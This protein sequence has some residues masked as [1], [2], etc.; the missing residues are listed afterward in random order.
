M[1]THSAHRSRPASG[2]RAS[3][4]RRFA[5]VASTVGASA[6]ALFPVDGV[7]AIQGGASATDM[8]PSVVRLTYKGAEL[9][10]GT[11]VGD[12]WVLSAYHCLT[13][14]NNDWGNIGVE[15]WRSGTVGPGDVY[16]SKVASAPK[17]PTGATAPTRNKTVGNYDLMLLPTASPMAPWVKTVPMAVGWPALGTTLTEYGYG[18]TSKSGAPSSS[19]QKT[20]DGDLK[21][22]SCDS[23]G[24]ADWKVGHICAQGSRSTAWEGDSGG[25]L[26]WWN[27]GYWQQVG[28]FSMYPG[29]STGVHWQAYWSE[30]DTA[31]R[32]WIAGI[33]RPSINAGTILR[34]PD[35][36]TSWLYGSDGY[37]HWIP[38]GTTYNCLVSQGSTSLNWNIRTI[39]SIPDMVGSG[40]WAHCTSPVTNPPP[41][42]T[43]AE[44]E[45]SH[46]VNTFTNYHNASGMGPRIDPYA[47]VQVSC[48]VYDPYIVSASP[49]GYWYRIAS[50][51]WNGAYYAP[52]NTFYNGDPIGGPYTHNTD[53]NVPN[54]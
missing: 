43:Y 11:V 35:T 27:N 4:W 52:A 18:R 1:A 31:T 26:L 10:T 20:P 21:R 29:A 24:S 41:P 54:C 19:L 14:T 16:R 51:P 13:A 48:K 3:L 44:Q 23:I 2:R 9:C 25:P 32:S 33:I 37:R 49:D 42:T 50:A 17:V 5:L 39:E 12:G 53:W 38:D 28:D 47:W 8:A 7:Q 22:I 40:G 36:G 30:S 15:V 46:G 6:L 34:N 45:G